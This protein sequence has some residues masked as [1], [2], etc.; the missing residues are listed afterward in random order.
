MTSSVAAAWS[1]VSFR[2]AT[3]AIAAK[4]T[5]LPDSKSFRV[6]VHLKLLIMRTHSITLNVKR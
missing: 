3:L 2:V 4:R 6:A 5:D 1:C